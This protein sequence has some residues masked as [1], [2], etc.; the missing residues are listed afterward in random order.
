M[1]DYIPF[2]A[3]PADAARL[4]ATYADASV[5]R[6][7]LA[8][9]NYLQGSLPSSVD[10]WLDPS[11]DGYHHALRQADPVKRQKMLSYLPSVPGRDL[12]ARE[13]SLVAPDRHSL[14]QFVSAL[15]SHCLSFSPKWLSVPQLPV[16]D[17]S[18]RHKVNRE[19]ALLTDQWRSARGF[20]GK[21]VLPL[22]FTN[23]RQYHGKTCWSKKLN[24]V[25]QCLGRCPVDYVWVVDESLNDQLGA[26]T[27]GKRFQDL[28]GFHEDLLSAIPGIRVI[29]GPY[30]AMNLVLW[31]RG[32]ARPA[33]GLGGGY[34]YYIPGGG[35]RRPVARAAVSPI[36]QQVVVGANLDRWF[37]QSISRLQ[38]GDSARRE[39]ASL[40]TELETIRDVEIG[41]D[42]VARFYRTWIDKIEAMPA[43]A[44]RLGL[45]EDLSTAY[46]LAK[47]LPDFPKGTG[48]NRKSARVVEQFMLRCL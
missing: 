40:K 25:K 14:G 11:V 37:T 4:S 8:R 31:A 45:F 24:L 42:Q 32:L 1:P 21:M 46:V 20:R 41:R 38:P 16:T 13:K 28:I 47:R 23:Q 29:A 48:H 12:L 10:L 9:I 6:T 27:F 3:G 30:W 7:S 19:L 35:A 17:E 2:V 5:F 44:R 18:E 36:R 15:M 39:L 33:V 43:P 26:S 22:I 34:K